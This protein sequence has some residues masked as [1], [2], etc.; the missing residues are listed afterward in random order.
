MRIILPILAGVAL[1]C[2]TTNAMENEDHQYQQQIQIQIQK[3]QSI[4]E[5]RPKSIKQT[6]EQLFKERTEETININKF[7]FYGTEDYSF[8]GIN[9]KDIITGLINTKDNII[10]VDVG[11]GNGKWGKTVLEHIKTMKEENPKLFFNKK[12]DIYSL[13][14]ESL[15]TIYGL[16]GEILIS[17]NQKIT[18]TIDENIKHHLLGKIE[19]ENISE[20]TIGKILKDKVD[21]IVS[22]YCF[23]HLCDAPGTI[24]QLRDLLIPKKGIMAADLASIDMANKKG[25]LVSSYLSPHYFLLTFSDPFVIQRSEPGIHFVLKRGNNQSVAIKYSNTENIQKYNH[26]WEKPVA[27]IEINDNDFDFNTNCTSNKLFGNNAGF[28]KE[29]IAMNNQKWAQYWNP[30]LIGSKDNRFNPL[31]DPIFDALNNKDLDDQKLG[32]LF[33]KIYTINTMKNESGSP[34]LLE[35][36]KKGKFRTLMENS[37]AID[38]TVTD[39][40]GDTA[41]HVVTNIEDIELLYNNVK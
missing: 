14:G 11:A 41:A 9:P 21:L 34:L 3:P 8:A 38:Y 23:M 6:I 4:Q 13:T 31:V 1:F 39:I 19:I 16:A 20:T 7:G 25:D 40:L 26:S 15:K 35:A 27:L 12:I 17:G 32:E 2:F 5:L 22:R 33:A 28:Y 29:L 24:I 30:L 10:I 36:I 18:K 37:N